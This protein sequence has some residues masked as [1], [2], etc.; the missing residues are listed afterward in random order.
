MIAIFT[1]NETG[2]FRGRFR[3]W[4]SFCCEYFFG[5]SSP[6]WYRNRVSTLI[7]P[8]FSGFNS[9]SGTMASVEFEKK[10]LI[11]DKRQVAHRGKQCQHCACWVL[12]LPDTMWTPVNKTFLIYIYGECVS[13]IGSWLWQPKKTCGRE[14]GRPARRRARRGRP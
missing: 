11:T 3:K 2:W 6:K 10:S 14:I 13:V 4:L 5:R 1:V 7:A 12:S 8:G 9:F